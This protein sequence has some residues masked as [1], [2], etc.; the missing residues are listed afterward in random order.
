MS[1]LSR[2]ID[3]VF[4]SLLLISKEVLFAGEERLIVIS[5]MFLFVVLYYFLSSALTSDF[6]YRTNVIKE[7]I[8]SILSLI[9][10]VITRT[11]NLLLKTNYI[12]FRLIKMYRSLLLE[13]HYNVYY[14]FNYSNFKKLFL[15]Y[16]L[17]NML[18]S[19]LSFIT[20]LNN[21]FIRSYMLSLYKY[22]VAW[23]SAKKVLWNRVFFDKNVNN[24]FLIKADS[25]L[26]AS[27]KSDEKS[28]PWFVTEKDWFS[29]DE[30]F[31]FK[32]LFN[33]KD[34]KYSIYNSI[35]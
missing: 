2:Y 28:R 17:T 15:Y 22:N 18:E 9:I 21:A 32:Y 4:I 6:E 5:Y 34:F 35:K 26:E 23:F 12:Y 7:E 20:Q 14:H 25:S 29:L 3:L 8:E 1:I 16:K 13:Y 10:S 30:N 24:N 31:K 11:R 27:R 33:F 19:S